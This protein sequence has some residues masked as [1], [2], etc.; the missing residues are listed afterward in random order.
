MKACSSL[1]NHIFIGK[2]DSFI[3]AHDYMS[4]GQLDPSTHLYAKIPETF[5]EVVRLYEATTFLNTLALYDDPELDFSKP[6]Y[7]TLREGADSFEFN[8]MAANAVRSTS[9]NWQALHTFPSLLEFTLTQKDFKKIGRLSSLHDL[10]LF[11][12]VKP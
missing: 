1:S 12:F 10:D 11:S 4:Q 3:T 6:N 2:G 9:D 7:L 5:P 8:L